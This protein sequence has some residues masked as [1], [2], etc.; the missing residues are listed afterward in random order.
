MIGRP[1]LEA[2][3]TSASAAAAAIRAGADRVELCSALEVGGVTPSQA[4]LEA[5]LATG[6][7]THVLVRCRPGDFVFDADEVDLMCGEAASVT[8]AGAAG[9]VIGALG[10]DG[11]LDLDVIAR[12]AAAAR[13]IRTDV[14]VTIHRAVD[15]SAD[16]IRCAA[17]LAASAIAPD[18]ILT[19]GGAPA[20]G[21]ALAVLHRMVSAAGPI[22][23]MAGGGVTVSA[24]PA[25]V[26]A[27][28]SAVHLSAKRRERDHWALDPQIV[29]ASRAALERSGRHG[30]TSSAHLSE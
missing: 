15:V 10:D 1:L 25:I 14:T 2:A 6:A 19:S 27:G 28:V 30:P 29:A 3:V 8:A 22:G 23:V 21:E 5:T 4:L 17:A 13:A 16:P 20:A 9:V 24:I 18:R 7:E 11:L 12:M 26:D